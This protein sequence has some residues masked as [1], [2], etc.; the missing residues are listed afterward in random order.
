VP[1]PYTLI[2]SV[3]TPEGTLALRQRGE[4][5]M[6]SIAG[7]VLMTSMLHRTEDAVATLGLVDAKK[8]PRPRILIGGLGLGFTLRAALD[9]LPRTAEVIVAEPNARVVDWCRGPVANAIGNALSDPRVRVEIDDA[10]AVVRR[11]KNLD[12]IVV[13]LYEGPKAIP[14][15]AL[16]PLYGRAAIGAVHDALG[17]GGT[18]AVWSEEPHAPFERSLKAAGFSVERVRAGGGGPRHAVYVAKKGGVRAMRTRRRR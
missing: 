17:E 3:E 12:A 13:D 4:D 10:M 5:F 8:K 15:G 6:V 18:Y 2:D 14:K 9:A 1:A 16:D 7:R 11:T